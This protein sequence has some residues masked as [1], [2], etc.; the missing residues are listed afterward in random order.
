MLL[1][2]G[3]ISVLQALAF[4]AVWYFN[5]QVPGVAWWG[6]AALLNGLAMALYPVRVVVDQPLLTMVLPTF[7]NVA[8]DVLFYLGAAAFTGRRPHCCWPAAVSI[9]LFLGY[10]WFLLVAPNPRLRPLMISPVIILFLGLGAWELLREQRV[11]LRFSARV[12]GGAAVLYAL[13]FLYRII[14]LPRLPATTGFLDPVAPQQSLF[15]GTILW[16]LFW[17]FGTMMLINQRQFLQIRQASEAELRVRE[18]AAALEKE[19]LAER[20]HRQ[21]QLLVRDLHDGLGGITAHLA[22]LTSHP[23]SG[24]VPG[25]LAGRLHDIRQLAQEGNRELRLLMN[26]LE[27]GVTHW[28]DFLA[29]LRN[30]ADKVCA[31]HGLDLGWTVTG[32]PPTEPAA[33]GPAMLSLLRAAK[34]AL[35]N[36]ARHARATRVSVRLAFRPRGLGMVIRDDGGGLPGPESPRRGRGLGNMRRRLQELGGRCRLAGGPGA[37]TAVKF[38]LPLPV[39]IVPAAAPTPGTVP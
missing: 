18:E 5:R 21:R 16:V 1:V 15:A 26:T 20:A 6:L 22:L 36:A 31:A 12:V 19:V 39:A 38:I 33:D 25:T 29:E 14:A 27:R 8:A 13:L 11:G 7:I 34:E 24:E 3:A 4:G 10:L 17:T 23:A 30:H 9:P 37:G 32:R 2:A 35:N 28:G